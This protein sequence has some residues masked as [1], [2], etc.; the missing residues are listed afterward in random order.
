MPNFAIPN[1]G[2]TLD[3]DYGYALTANGV[4]G[5]IVSTSADSTLSRSLQ[6]D[7]FEMRLEMA[8][9]RKEKVITLTPDAV[10]TRALGDAPPS[11][12]LEITHA[13]NTR[14]LLLVEDDS[15][16]LHWQLPESAVA[17]PG[18]RDLA[19]VSRF[20]VTIAPEASGARGLFSK[21]LK[22][23]VYPVVDAILGPIVEG[24]A[25]RWESRNRP[26]LVRSF[27]PDDYTSE[28]T[29]AALRPE[30]WQ[31]LA[32]G[33]ALLWVHGTFSS[34]AAFAGIP[35]D[36][37]RDLTGAYGGRSFAFNHFTLSADPAEN[38]RML[39][40]QIPAGLELEVDIV[41]HSRGG[42]VSRELARLGM[43]AGQNGRLRVRRI[44]FVAAPNAGTALADDDH[45]V[46]MIDRFTTLVKFFP[47][48]TAQK[49]L[50]GA[51]TALKLLG[52][53]LLHDLPGLRAM[54]PN[55]PYLETLNAPGGTP[56]EHFAIAADFEPKPGEPLFSVTRLEDGVMDRVFTDV[57]NDLVVPRDG[58]A[59]NNGAPGFPIPAAR[60][61]IFDAK[62]GVIH[63]HFFQFQATY[64][65]LKAWLT[66]DGARDLPQAR[67]A[68]RELSPG[69]LA[70][71]RPHVVN[72]SEGKFKQSGKY[73]TS[74]EDVDAIF[75]QHL[76]AWRQQQPAGQPLRVVFFAH[77]G[78]VGEQ[79][80]LAI[81]QKHVAW[82]KRNGVY[83]IYF[84][85]ETGLFDAI[86][87][88]LS[89]VA[90]KVPG[91]GARDI[92][93][94]TTDPVVELGARALGGVKVWGAMKAN[95]RLASEQD[96]GARYVAQRLTEFCGGLASQGAAIELHAV[97]HSAGSIFHAHFLPAAASLGVPAFR[98]L[99]L[100]APAID[101]DA[102]KERLLPLAGKAAGRITMY[103]MLR[104]YEK[105][106]NCIGV[107]H[108][109][110]LY[111]IYNALE[112]QRST[113]I[114]G[115]EESARKDMELRRL[116]GLDGSANPAAD[117]VWSVTSGSSGNSASQSTSHGGFDDDAAT[118]SSVAAR[119]L[120]LAAAPVP[121]TG[122][123]ARDLTA[124]PISTEWLDGFDLTEAAVA[125]RPVPAT[126][127]ARVEPPPVR[128]AAGSVGA[129]TSGSNGAKEKAAPSTSKMSESA[130]SGARRKALCVGIDAYPAPNT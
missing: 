105:A 15:G 93:D 10:Q 52:H 122:T 114:V 25:R 41:C 1:A 75:Q 121:Y 3:L 109:S 103:S 45:M 128:V 61:M 95:A 47:S 82:W 50:E 4:T 100:L 67:V 56:P 58:V 81:A 70:A 57:A 62:D 85:W 130:G 22:T 94:Y 113:P 18:A 101:V 12:T 65:H 126:A 14:T 51:V 63:T 40:A 97:G 46:E 36:V 111:L 99:Q 5:R 48:P 129:G 38:A 76:P 64:D 42:L 117:V 24:F 66:A 27:R 106:D 112:S 98:T 9:L 78:L 8:G 74:P 37:L 88:I 53:A 108:K 86:R 6:A 80:G 44:V 34:A 77:G 104:D 59:A 90:S 79:D 35:V 125:M 33:P 124:W 73:Y 72:L 68:P 71:L 96:G 23:F 118:M 26:Y 92:W 39:L 87:S 123:G 21:I 107:Y 55:G 127:P 110:L 11:V 83:P 19:M 31:E 116:F 13:P 54:N 30:Q 2:E 7:E 115:L 17:G 91:L 102:F 84:V 43:V 20:T 28:G 119:V 89:S 49:I 16:A 29:I 120:G 60:Q 32:Q 69:E